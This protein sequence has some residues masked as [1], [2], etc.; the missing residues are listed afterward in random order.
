VEDPY[1]LD[2]RDIRVHRDQQLGKGNYGVVFRGA[3]PTS[4][5][6]PAAQAQAQAQGEGGRRPRA[7]TI[8]LEDGETLPPAMADAGAGADTDA[9]AGTG[10][11]LASLERDVAIKMLPQDRAV[12]ERERQ[13]FW[14]EVK[15]MRRLQCFGGHAN[16]VE[17]VGYVVGEEMMLLLEY[18]PAPNF[19]LWHAMGGQQRRCD[20]SPSRWH[21]E[22]HVCALGHRG[23]VRRSGDQTH[24][25]RT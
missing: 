23:S 24:K 25:A 15:F 16:I 12:E 2:P 18:V 19:W 1:A 6:A 9:D 10:A 3:A 17:F 13:D 22:P 21:G 20:R 5:G 4:A 11:G 7:M 14:E 8:W